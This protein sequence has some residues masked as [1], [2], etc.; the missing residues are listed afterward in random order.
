MVEEG[1]WL[2]VGD[3]GKRK[4]EGSPEGKVFHGP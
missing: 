3:V 2:G 4:P 1:Y